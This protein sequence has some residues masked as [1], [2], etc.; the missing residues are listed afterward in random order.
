[1]LRMKL[2]TLVSSLALVAG[3]FTVPALA[4]QGTLPPALQAAVNSGNANQI[5]QVINTLAGGNNAQRA[6]L[7]QQ[8]AAAAERL[9]SVNPQAAAAAI[10]SALGV[11]STTA[12]QNAAPGAANAVAAAAARLAASP[13]VQQ[14]GLSAGI[15]ASAGTILSN[16]AVVN[17]NQPAASQAIAALAA[18]NNVAAAGG[19][20]GGGS[21][22]GGTS[23]GG[24][25]GSGG[26]SGSGGAGGA[27]GI[28]GFTTGQGSGNGSPD[29]R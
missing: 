10:E 9:A 4:Q 20:G 22:G 13:G 2:L 5:T 28:G 24:A 11:F 6:N 21:G 26:A 12:M 27:G 15:A 3:T 23:P 19:A 25:G 14:T 18:I 8:V 1:M 16:Q 17:A 7:A 29:G